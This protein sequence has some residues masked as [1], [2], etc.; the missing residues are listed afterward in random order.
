MTQV[1]QLE[2]LPNQGLEDLD[3]IQKLINSV[4]TPFATLVDEVL[5]EETSGGVGSKSARRGVRVLRGAAAKA[6]SQQ[7]VTLPIFRKIITR[8]VEEAGD[9]ELHF[10][11]YRRSLR[12]LFE[13]TNAQSFD[14]DV[15]VSFFLNWESQKRRWDGEGDFASEGCIFYD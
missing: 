13:W 5:E 14:R 7:K 9:P 6:A 3:G 12:K 11:A 8:L 15:F 2:I 10:Y 4:D 1:T